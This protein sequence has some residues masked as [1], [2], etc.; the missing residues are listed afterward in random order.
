M[1][2]RDQLR[3]MCEY[4]LLC[5]IQ[6][7]EKERRTKQVNHCIL[8]DITNQNPLF[9][10]T[11]YFHNGQQQCDNCIADWLNEEYDERW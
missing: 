11:G 5:I 4:D 8:S 10:C 9:R 6:K 3:Q 1:K 7:N 2:N